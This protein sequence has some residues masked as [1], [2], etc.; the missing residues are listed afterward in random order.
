M[1]NKKKKNLKKHGS[2]K[3]MF[4]ALFW[5]YPNIPRVIKNEGD[6]YRHSI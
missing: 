5:S 2:K 1:L 4:T 6:I 3:E